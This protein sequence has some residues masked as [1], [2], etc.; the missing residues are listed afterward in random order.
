MS[1]RFGACARRSASSEVGAFHETAVYAFLI[2]E[3]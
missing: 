1:L 2:A 3:S